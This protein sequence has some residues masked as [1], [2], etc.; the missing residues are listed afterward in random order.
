[1][2]EKIMC[3]VE[4]PCT[5]YVCILDMRFLLCSVIQEFIH[6]LVMQQNMKLEMQRPEKENNF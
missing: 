2:C 1:M 3:Y 5:C 6:E 4:F